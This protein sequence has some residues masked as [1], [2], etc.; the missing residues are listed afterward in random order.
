MQWIKSYHTSLYYY[1][2]FT[3]KR[4]NIVLFKLGL[5]C[6]KGK[7]IDFN[8]VFLKDHFV[9]GTFQNKPINRK[10]KII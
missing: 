8:F 7:K 5:R 6:S 2:S 3:Q 4:I 1:D 10:V 9:Y